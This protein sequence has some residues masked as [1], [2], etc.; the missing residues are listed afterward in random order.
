MFIM[1]DDYDWQ[2]DDENN[3][4]DNNIFLFLFFCYAL[5]RIEQ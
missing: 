1:N 3:D 5:T 4:D 2:N